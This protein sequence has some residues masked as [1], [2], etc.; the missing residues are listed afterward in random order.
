MDKLNPYRAI[1]EQLLSEIVQVA[2]QSS[3]ATPRFLDRAVFDRRGDNYMIVREDGKVRAEW[4]AMSYTGRSST[5]KSGFRPITP[6]RRS[7]GS[8]KPP[9]FRSAR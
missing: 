4:I 5:I 1:I 8:W 3:E 2:E 9:A 7:R 6:T